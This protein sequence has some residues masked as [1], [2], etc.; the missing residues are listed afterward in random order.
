M[1]AAARFRA[2]DEQRR[3]A[4]RAEIETDP[5]SADPAAPAGVWDPLAVV[6]AREEM[7]ELLGALADLDERDLHVVWLSAVGHTD[8]EIAV[9]LEE[10]SLGPRLSPDAIRQRRSRAVKRLREQ[11][12][13]G[14][15]ERP[16]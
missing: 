7:R 11:L 12:G 10:L 2:L 8:E 14:E 15:G 4:R 3:A 1:V 5:V 13:R 6:L 9:R 16:A